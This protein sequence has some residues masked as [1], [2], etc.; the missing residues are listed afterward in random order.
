MIPVSKFFKF[1]SKRDKTL[2][3]LSNIAALVAGAILPC[4]A[5]IMGEVTNTFDPRKGSDEV[6]DTMRTIAIVVCMVGVGS[7]IFGYIYYAFA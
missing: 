5:I 2:M 1:I 4:M 6:L 7:L 3:I